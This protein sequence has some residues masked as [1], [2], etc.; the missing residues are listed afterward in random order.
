MLIVPSPLASVSTKIANSG[1]VA[2]AS[3]REMPPSRFLSSSSKRCWRVWP[4]C[5]GTEPR[6]AELPPALG[7]PPAPAAGDA[8]FS[9]ALSCAA[10]GREMS[11]AQAPQVTSARSLMGTLLRLID[12]EN[13]TTGARAILPRCCGQIADCCRVRPGERIPGDSPRQIAGAM[14]DDRRFAALHPASLRAVHQAKDKRHARRQR[15]AHEV[16][17]PAQA[18]ERQSLC[19]SL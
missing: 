11:S 19:H 12:A 2:C 5:A 14:S 9:L 10:A 7:A 18:R 13:V 3:L 15:A 1:G 17:I 4:C 16:D 6:A 8:L